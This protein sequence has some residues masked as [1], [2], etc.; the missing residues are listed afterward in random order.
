MAPRFPPSVQQ[1]AEDAVLSNLF[2]DPMLGTPLPVYI[3][4]DVQ[5]RENLV[6]LVTVRIVLI[7]CSSGFYCLV[8]HAGG[9]GAFY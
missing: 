5:D 9:L 1:D 2:I 7:A 6:D 3:E 8:F 4:K